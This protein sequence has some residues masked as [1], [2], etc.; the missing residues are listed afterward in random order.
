MTGSDILKV[1]AFPFRMYNVKQLAIDTFVFSLSFQAF[2]NCN[3]S[4]AK[5]ILHIAIE[6]EKVKRVNDSIIIQFDP[7]ALEIPINWKPEFKG[8]DKTPEAKLLPLP[9]TPPLEIKPI[10]F[11]INGE[12]SL[13]EP[14]QF[15]GDLLKAMK[16]EA[17]QKKNEKIKKEKVEIKPKKIK[18]QVKKP[19]KK[20]KKQKIIIEMTKKI[21]KIKKIKKVKKKKKTLL[22]FI[23]K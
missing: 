21:K 2:E 23:N 11:E 9:D 10:S 4:T 19:K 5:K 22:D 6:E 18:T 1:V 14:F 17:Q 7:W 20:A 15:D 3:I 12:E 16:A 8:L 13:T